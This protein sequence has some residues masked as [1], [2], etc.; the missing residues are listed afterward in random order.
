M[1]K[2]LSRRGGWENQ[3]GLSDSGKKQ[4]NR[5]FAKKKILKEVSGDFDFNR[6]V[7]SQNIKLGN[8]D[9]L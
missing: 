6:C 3:F 9:V 1:K 8:R 4:V 2:R 5:K 7:V